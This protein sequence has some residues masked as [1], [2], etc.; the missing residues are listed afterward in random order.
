MSLKEDINYSLWCDFIE[1]DFLENRFKEIIKKG[2]IQGATSNPA[3]FESS[4][5]NSV[6][7]SKSIIFFL[8]IVLLSLKRINSK[9]ILSF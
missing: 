4:I 1:R 3:I 5:S 6:A 8:K 7:L 2:I 9:I